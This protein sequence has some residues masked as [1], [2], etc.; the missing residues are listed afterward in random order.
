[1][2]ADRKR[3]AAA[4][5]AVTVLDALAACSGS[6][7]S[8]SAAPT[9]GTITVPGEFGGGVPAQATGAE[10]AGTIT[11]AM[12]PGSAPTWILPVIPAA[13][14]T[15]SDSFMFDNQMYPQLYFTTDG[16][17]PAEDAAL[18]LAYD[19][20]YSNGD[21]TVSITLK[22]R[23]TWSD[24]QPVTSKDLLFW[25]D[26][27]KA[28]VA[29]SPAN[30]NRYTP[31][32]GIP[33][34]VADAATPNASTFVLHLKKAVNPAWLTQTLLATIQPM[35]SHAWAKD[36]ADGPVLDFTNPANAAKIY[37]YLAAQSRS[38]STYATDPLWQVVDGP[39]KLTAFDPT[40]GAF[41]MVP[42]PA[43]GGP[44]AAVE[45][46]YQAV[47]FASDTAEYDAVKSGAVDIGYI[48][49]A[50]I[51]DASAVK[52]AYNIFGYD[53]FGFDFV[54]YNFEDPTGDFD[55]IIGQL[56]I[57]QAIAHLQDEAGYIKAFFDGAA[58]PAYGPVP[59]YPRSPYTPPD[60]T[61]DPYP[62]SVPDAVAL[63]KNHGWNVV[64]GGTDT[65][66]RPGTGSGECGAGI[67][68][69]TSLAWNLIYATDPA[70]IG[71]EVTDLASEA[72]QAGITIN[73]S[74]SNLDYMI[75]NY[76]DAAAPDNAGKW[77]MIDFGGA[78]FHTYPTTNLLFNTGG[79]L[80]L[81]GYSNPTADKLID[82]SISSSNPDAVAQEASYL[83]QQQP[84]L[85]HPDADSTSGTTGL[86]AWRKN[87]SGP[88]ISFEALTQGVWEPQLWFLTR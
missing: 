19:P 5:L 80:N 8:P 11:V 29:E 44:H 41:T 61:T 9:P 84:G 6:S 1:M 18:S 68:A 24:G 3:V 15:V 36:S 42:N 74:G 69:G 66:A 64:P 26:E 2:R 13:A 14:A 7:G 54:A 67:P 77:A 46:A 73:L 28:A 32:M 23:L 79:G 10:Q 70:V 82:A 31:G 40:T 25:Y 63:L 85:F 57:R 58:D 88:P 27:M 81:G 51:A 53:T 49:S 60:A 38:L 33:D 78:K 22:P 62:F 43:Y 47:S 50:D 34:D 21:T 52:S 20:V 30:W 65:C 37:T 4:I 75:E 48:P 35:P 72:R 56:Y 83:T 17:K 55:H 76:N 39:Y 12:P 59:E 86:Q 71:Q 87:V 16:V 45:S